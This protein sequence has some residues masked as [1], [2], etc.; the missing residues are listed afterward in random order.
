MIKKLFTYSTLLLA[1]TACSYDEFDAPSGFG[2]DGEVTVNLAV[3]EM[4]TVKTRAD[5][6]GVSNIMMLVLSDQGVEDVLPYSITDSELTQN[7]SQYQLRTKLDQNIRVKSGLKFYF[8]ANAPASVTASNLKG[9]PEASLLALETKDLLNGNNMSMAGSID[10]A[11]LQSGNL[12]SLR[13]NAAK[14]TV[15]D[16]TKNAQGVW[17]PG[18][19]VYPVEVYGTAETSSVV[20][21]AILDKTYAEQ[22]TSAASITFIGEDAAYVHR[23]LNPGRDNQVRPFMIVKAPFEGTDYFY[24]LE[25][26][27]YDEAAKEFKKLDLLSN[28]HYQVIIEE[29]MGKGDANPTAASKNPTSLIKATIYDYSPQA[30]N[31]ITDGSRELGVS[32]QLVHNGA[33]TTDA[34][35]PYLYIKVYSPDE[36]EL[37]GANR[38]ITLSSN[39]SWLKFGNIAA[40]NAAENV[41]EAIPG[42]D[43]YRGSVLRVPV[44]FE[45]T[46]EPG[47]LSATITV[48]WKGL[49]REVPVRW[50]RDF[51]AS[52]LCTAQLIIRDNTGAEKFRTGN[53]TNDNYWTFIADNTK[54][55]GL[56]VEQNN[57]K[58]RNEGLH[59]PVNYGG[60]AA[61]WTYTYNLSFKNLNDGAAYDWRVSTQGLTGITLSKTSGSNVTGNA[62]FTVTH[63]GVAANWNYEVGTLRFELSKPGEN[64][65]TAYEID[66]YHTGFFDNPASFR[67]T[68]TAHRVDKPET[69][70]FYYYEVVEGPAGKYY[71][72]DRNLGATSAEYYIE[73]VV[74]GSEMTYYGRSNEARGGYYR[75]AKYNNGGE[76]QMY[77]DLCPPG[78]EVPRTEVWNTL[79]N[80]P[81]FIT[82]RTGNYYQTYF[83]NTAGQTVFFPRSRHY[84]GSTKEGDSRAGYYWT[85]T[86]ADGL[87]KDHIGNW[88]KYLK[89]SGNIASYDN[90]EVEGRNYSPGWAMSVR[91][92]NVTV[93]SNTYLRTYFNVQGATHV[94]LYS[95][96]EN[97]NKNAVTN[98]PGK[99]IGNYITMGNAAGTGSG[100]QNFYFSYESPT[101]NPNDYYVIFT[102]R[103]NNGIWHTMSKGENGA[104]IYSTNNRLSAMTG[105]KVIG[106]E[107]DGV[108]TTLGGTWVCDYQPG[109]GSA[110]VT[111]KETDE[112]IVEPDPVPDMLTIYYTNPNNW[113][114]VSVYAWNANDNDNNYGHD[115]NNPIPMTKQADGTWM[116]QIDSRCTNIIFKGPGNAQTDDIPVV[117]EDNHVYPE[118]TPTPPTP[119]TVDA[120]YLRGGISGWNVNNTYKFSSTDNETFTLTVANMNTENFKI[121]G[122]E[123]DWSGIN[124]G[125]AGTGLTDRTVNLSNG[126]GDMSLAAGG[127]VTFTLK[128]NGGNWQLTIKH[129]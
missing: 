69:N 47:E 64:N 70:F 89:F 7:G 116:A 46:P 14:V 67:S 87:E 54:I 52:E 100:T 86:Q 109:G 98:W 113:S 112:P 80:N 90:A 23:T 111:F 126:G 101:T 3:P 60:Q 27:T 119:T 25:F 18:T 75:A 4:E 30:F 88:L 74:N 84:N 51:D 55:D 35:R 96:D 28:H 41:G 9:L 61:R 19:T 103:D 124:L 20:S 97:G 40:T 13:R 83:T 65:W 53:T 122:P 110:K 26:E 31:M 121:S 32:A 66:L 73:S 5:E 43:G 68:S 16:G 115:W 76:P 37:N 102:F 58:V 10:L 123:S 63:D 57:G 8:I 39:V 11:S 95:L 120:I 99:A 77:S 36:A 125:G 17:T 72:L 49:S 108:E 62:D 50:T 105:W 34:T 127:N 93:P 106:D 33:P 85:A 15:T 6:N 24:R 44:T 91:C 29:V 128:R 22:A 21:G 48:T 114:T 12:V 42:I 129:N 107:I 45:R 118:T 82:S 79:R 117:P 38:A 104:T 59:F 78:F 71:W 92:V 1:M 2:P 56:S 81:N 94:F